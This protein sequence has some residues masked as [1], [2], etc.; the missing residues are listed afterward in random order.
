MGKMKWDAQVR[1]KQAK[2]RTLGQIVS[3][4][5][6]VMI[7]MEEAV[8]SA[9]DDIELRFRTLEEKEEFHNYKLDKQFVVENLAKGNIDV[10]QLFGKAPYTAY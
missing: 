7:M 10:T 6:T 3:R 8:S 2:L 1:M 5:D 4:S 9:K